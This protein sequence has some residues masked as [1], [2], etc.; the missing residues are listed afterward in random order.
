MRKFCF[1]RSLLLV[2]IVFIF[3]CSDNKQ[4][5][6]KFA[7]DHSSIIMNNFD[8]AS[9]LQLR[10]AYA[11]NADSNRFVNV[12]VQPSELDSLQDEIPIAGKV[13]LK[14]DS[15]IFIP[16]EPFKKNKSYVVESF[17]NVKFANSEKL[18]SGHGNYNLKPQR[19]IL[20]W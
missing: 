6:I 8:E 7:D 15:L 16:A 4:A 12:L 2:M 14:G 13:N 10:N 19:Q 1:N 5:S 3:S 20:K 17:I 9:L 11:E 18:I